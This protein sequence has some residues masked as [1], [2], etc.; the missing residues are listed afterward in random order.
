ME[1]NRIY[2]VVKKLEAGRSI[3][4]EKKQ[5]NRAEFMEFL[6]I[7]GHCKLKCPI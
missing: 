3:K 2:N 4:K 5:L 1:V 6:V 7:L